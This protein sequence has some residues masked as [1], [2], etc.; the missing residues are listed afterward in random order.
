[1]KRRAFLCGLTLGTLAAPLAVE[2][3]GKVPLVGF[4]DPHS[5]SIAAPYHDAFRQGLRDRGYVDGQNIRI[6]YRWA[7]GKDERLPDLAAE[8]VRLQVNVMVTGGPQATRAATEATSSIP[9]VMVAVGADPVKMR[10]VASLARP[11]GNI[12]GSTLLSPEL[13]AKRLQLLKEAVPKLARVGVLWNSANP[14]KHQDWEETP[15]AARALGVIVQSVEV[16]RSEQFE[17]AD[18]AITREH[19]DALLVLDDSLTF[20]HRKRIA[21]FAVKNGLPTVCALK[22][23]ADAGS[24]MSYSS[25]L[26]DDFRR[27]ATYVDKLLK[28]AKA[29]D[30]PIEEPTT[31]ELVINMK[32]AKALKLRVPPSV[33][34]QATR[35]IE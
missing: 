31:F 23:Y 20:R 25:N 5:P 22:E 13:S 18:A 30:L 15:V 6:E 1:M 2:A 7:D 4:L 9:I 35:V 16:Q 3:Q 28:G 14:A 8:L 26:L 27:A 33:L 24:L 17:S 32:T 11:G 12:T 19:P 34:L 10:L 21:E 29:A